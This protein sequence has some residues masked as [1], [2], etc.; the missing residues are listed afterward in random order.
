MA[1]VRAGAGR[2]VPTILLVPDGVSDIARAGRNHL[3]SARQPMAFGQDGASGSCGQSHAPHRRG[4][5]QARLRGLVPGRPVFGSNGILARNSAAVPM[6]DL[7]SC[8]TRSPVVHGLEKYFGIRRAVD[9]LVSR[10]EVK[11]DRLGCYGRSMGSTHTWL[12]A[13]GNPACARWWAIAVCPPTP[14]SIAPA[15]C[16]VSR[17]SSRASTSTA[18]GHRRP[19]CAAR[20][21]P[22]PRRN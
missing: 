9:Y 14:A 13:R 6:K 20:A 17:T 22:E 8:A 19:H 1:Y 4:T 16:I 12:V 15:C 5:G 18:A 11:A 7:N 10:P 21:P 2:S 3:A